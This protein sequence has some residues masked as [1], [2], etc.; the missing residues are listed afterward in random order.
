MEVEDGRGG[1]GDREEN[2][3]KVRPERV[4]AIVRFILPH[5]LHFTASTKRAT[6][7]SVQSF[8]CMITSETKQLHSADHYGCI[9][10][11]KFQLIPPN[12]E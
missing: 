2:R 4:S 7:E 6:S 8:L 9:E 5:I 12:P 3:R 11:K 1:G 10:P